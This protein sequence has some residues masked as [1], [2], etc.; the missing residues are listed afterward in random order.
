MFGYASVFAA[1][2]VQVSNLII[3]VGACE[4]IN[5]GGEHER[6]NSVVSSDWLN[7]I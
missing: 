2:L 3:V 4:M 7:I 6:G 1:R 5:P